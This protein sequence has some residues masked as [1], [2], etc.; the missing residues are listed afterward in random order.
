M[1]EE[2]FMEEILTVATFF[3]LLENNSSP[4]VRKTNGMDDNDM[5]STYNE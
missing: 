4:E 3:P 1:C 5:L 2:G